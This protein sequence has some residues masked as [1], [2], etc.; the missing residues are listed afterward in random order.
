MTISCGTT[1]DVTIR[2]VVNGRFLN[3][4]STNDW[5]LGFLY[6]AANIRIFNRIAGLQPARPTDTASE[7]LKV[8]YSR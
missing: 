8:N 7:P 2:Q 3:V 6:R 1:I 5:I 4:Y